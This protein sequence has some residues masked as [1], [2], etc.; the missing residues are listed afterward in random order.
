MH[1]LGN[2]GRRKVD[3][4]ALLDGGHDGC[5]T[6]H[7][8]ATDVVGQPATLQLDVYEPWTREPAHRSTAIKTLHQLG[9][10]FGCWR[11]LE[12]DLGIYKVFM[13]SRFS[14]CLCLLAY[15]RVSS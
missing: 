3:H 13:V 7:K 5:S 6:V 10:I 12:T 1:L 9:T 11:H 4:H 2:V 8:H 14:S 15:H